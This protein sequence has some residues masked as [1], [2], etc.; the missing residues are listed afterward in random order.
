MRN[1]EWP[2]PRVDAAGLGGR[3]QPSPSSCALALP[4]PLRLGQCHVPRQPADQRFRVAKYPL[5]RLPES[6]ARKIM[7]LLVA[8]IR[9][10]PSKDQASRCKSTS[11][12]PAVAIIINPGNE[13][14]THAI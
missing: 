10:F 3:R 6:V 13:I 8:E 4:G 9:L 1:S 11:L 14:S 7:L 12:A 2:G 5:Y